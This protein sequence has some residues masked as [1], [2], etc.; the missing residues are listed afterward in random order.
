MYKSS[1]ASR[2]RSSQEEEAVRVS[3]EVNTINTRGFWRTKSWAKVLV[4]TKRVRCTL[5]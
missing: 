3:R 2:P 1:R 4:L 5:M